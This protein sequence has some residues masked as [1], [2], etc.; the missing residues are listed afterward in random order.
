M[1]A[2][3]WTQGFPANSLI[4]PNNPLLYSVDRNLRTPTM[5]QWH[6]G[7]R[8][9]TAQRDDAGSLLWLGR[10]GL[11]FMASTTATRPHPVTIPMRHWQTVVLSRTWMEPL[12]RFGPIQTP[13]TTHCRLVLKNA[14]RTGS[15]SRRHTPTHMPRTK[16]RA[17]V[18]VR[19]ATAI[20]ATSASPCS[21]METPIST[22]GIAS[23]SATPT[24]C[25]SDGA[26]A[27]PEMPAAS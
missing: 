13:T 10:T 4:D 9:P 3:F 1:I 18:L 16:L 17:Q 2:N 19:W 14:S 27:S 22:C 15:C 23:R 24:T 26:S 21:S 8:I 12:L 6:L 11:I 5:H 7:L 20:F 25:R